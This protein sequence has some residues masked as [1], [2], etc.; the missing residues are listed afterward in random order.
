MKRIFGI[1]AIKCEERW[2][3]LFVGLLLLFFNALVV[4]RYYDSFTQVDVNYYNVIIRHFRM[5]GFDPLT[6]SVISDWNTS[7]NVY[8]HPLLAFY[9]YV[10]YLINQGLMAVTGIN[11]ALFLAT[12]IPL[13]CGFYSAIFLGRIF[14][15]VIGIGAWLSHLLTV[16]Y[17]AFGYVL[18][19]SIV[20]DHFIISMLLLIMALYVSGRR[21]K[22]GRPLKAWQTVIYFLLTAGTSLNN[23]LKIYLSCLFVNG[24]R[25]FRPKHLLAIVVPAALLWGFARWEYK[26]FVW[27]QEMARKEA[28]AKKA[29]VQKA[30]EQKAKAEGKTV[31]KK[32]KKKRHVMGKPF[33]QGEFMRWTDATTSRTD[34][35]VENVFGE[36]IQLHP[37]YFLQDVL[38]NRPVIVRYRYAANYVVEGIVVL[39]FLCGIWAGRRSKFLWLAMSYFALDMALHLGLGFG[40]NEVFIMTC[41]YMFVV[42]IAIAFLL[43]ATKGKQ[44]RALVG[45]T[46][47]L[48]LYLLLYNGIQLANY[49]IS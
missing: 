32:A 28:R 25:I 36:A 46:A 44:R 6:Y 29:E 7:Y 14:R 41:H 47:V 9:M 8:R 15:E 17:F 23:G 48:T 16:F 49:L 43:K 38:I 10:P 22:S 5:S 19:T 34:A 26:T 13:F 37:D 4:V 12:L 1:F 30:K 27:P 24:K 11:C 21:M 42:P 33:M 3:A 45:M 31:K 18:V 39:L 40:L 2:L 35:L 20:A